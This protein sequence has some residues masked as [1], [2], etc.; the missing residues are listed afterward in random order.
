MIGS[1]PIESVLLGRYKRKQIMQKV[2]EFNTEIYLHKYRT[3]AFRIE[4]VS[5]E[6]EQLYSFFGQIGN[7]KIEKAIYDL[8]S[9]PTVEDN[10]EIY[11]LV[12]LKSKTY[13]VTLV[14]DSKSAFLMFSKTKIIKFFNK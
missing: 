9:Y 14:I 12:H 7:R 4:I 5:I 2:E 1:E 6:K 3:N 11:D 8:K 13:D 10:K